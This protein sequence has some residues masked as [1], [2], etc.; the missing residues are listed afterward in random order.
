MSLSEKQLMFYTCILFYVY[1]K[2][3]RVQTDDF[4]M[5]SEDAGLELPGN[6][7]PRGRPQRRLKDEETEM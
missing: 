5:Y 6:W 4:C 2:T 7:G 1:R 3:R